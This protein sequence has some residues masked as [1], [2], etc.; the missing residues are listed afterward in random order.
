MGTVKRLSE[1]VERELRELHSKLCK[2]V[3]S[4]MSLA[5]GAMTEGRTPNAM[6]LAERESA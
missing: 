1:E 4:K 3:V 2:T 5:V 6:E